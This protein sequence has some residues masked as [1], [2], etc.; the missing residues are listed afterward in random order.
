MIRNKTNHTN[1]QWIYELALPNDQQDC[2]TLRPIK[3][4]K[5]KN[6]EEM[7]EG[8]GRKEERAKLTE[9]EINRNT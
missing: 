3:Q 4:K 8:K 2:Q 1:T 6:K 7:K 9:S 5:E